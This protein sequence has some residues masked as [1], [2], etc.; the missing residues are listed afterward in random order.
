M[1]QL[2]HAKQ[3]DGQSPSDLHIY[4]DS[5]EKHFD[6]S[7]VKQQALSFYAE[8][9]AG[10]QDHINLHSPTLP[11]N[12][13]FLVTARLL[14]WLI[15]TSGHLERLNSPLP[16]RCQEYGTPKSQEGPL[17][18]SFDAKR[19]RGRK[20]RLTSTSGQPAPE[21]PDRLTL[22]P[23]EPPKTS[24]GGF[25]STLNSGA[26]GSPTHACFASTL[27]ATSFLGF[28]RPRKAWPRMRSFASTL[29]P[30]GLKT[31]QIYVFALVGCKDITG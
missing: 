10:L 5:L 15:E 7:A 11:S 2:E 6:R 28:S 30:A 17:S 26:T 8:L 21:N 1:R 14:S 24:N 12:L 29:K 4:F 23:L 19:F 22:Q 27:K 16:R 9:Q 3:R 13:V 20:A 18:F 25:T 31:R